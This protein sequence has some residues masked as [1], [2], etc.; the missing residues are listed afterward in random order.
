[1]KKTSLTTDAISV[2]KG[3]AQIM[4]QDNVWTGILFLAAICYDSW[5]MGAIG[6]L[7]S[8]IGTGTAKVLKFSEEN[9]QSGLYGF[10]AVLIGIALVFYFELNVWVWIAI[11]V[12]CILSTLFMEWALRKKIPV[13]TFP[14]ILITWIAL[15]LLSIPDIAVRTVPSHFVDIEALSDFLVAGHA[16][17]EVI[18]QGSVIAGIIFFV[19]VFVSSPIAALYGFVATVL[20]AAISHYGQEPLDQINQGLFSF[21]AVLCGIAASGL[22]PR[23]GLYV[24]LAV[25]LSTVADMIMVHFGWATLT[26]PFVFAMWII[27]PLKYAVAKAE[28][29]FRRSPTISHEQ[30][31]PFEKV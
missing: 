5:L 12:G 10:N 22:K 24:L 25:F 27:V 15:F 26:F 1:M 3:F 4:L 2:L 30:F 20:S 23:D 14:F 8:L 31:K 13:F 18:F 17:G 6:L 21:N 29:R 28:H 7:S 19:G 16:F 9:I 11:V